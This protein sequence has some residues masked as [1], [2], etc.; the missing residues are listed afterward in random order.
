MP[1]FMDSGFFVNR[2]LD[3]VTGF[4]RLAVKKFLS[5]FLRRA[6]LY[7]HGPPW[8]TSKLKREAS[9]PPANGLI[10]IILF[11]S[12]FVTILILTTDLVELKGIRIHNKSIFPPFLL[13]KKHKVNET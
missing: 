1:E 9:C 12:I 3:L 4:W 7:L 2:Y 8:R 11:F 5:F 10:Q 13:L 6:F